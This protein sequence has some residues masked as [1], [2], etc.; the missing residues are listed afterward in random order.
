[1]NNFNLII[2]IHSIVC[3][4]KNSNRSVYQL[5]GTEDALSEIKKSVD[6][7][8]DKV[9]MFSSHKV[10]EEA[11]KYYRDL[12]LDYQRVPSGVFLVVSELDFVDPSSL[13]SQVET[14][15]GL[16][17]LCLDQVSDVHNA[18]AILRTANFYGVDFVIVPD[19]KSFGLTPS[20]FRI[21]SGAAEYT[22]IV[23]VSKLTK[24]LTKLKSLGVEILALS[25]HAKGKLTEEVVASE[26]TICLVLG[27][28]SSGI[29]HSVLRLIE[30]HISLESF[31]EVKSLNVSIAAAIA[32]ER[33]FG[34][35]KFS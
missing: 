12:K 17:I 31:G 22:K 21:S 33:C 26:Q 13:Y 28:E 29:G 9:R 4:L 27:K 34:R 3:A 25:E 11:K 18:A 10:Q 2:G 8:T 6:L 35:S 15:S 23:A 19:K 32:M 14:S 1:M 24:T 7:P 16:K 20:F 30:N 5:V